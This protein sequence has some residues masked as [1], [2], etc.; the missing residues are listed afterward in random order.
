MRS[1]LPDRRG[2]LTTSIVINGNKYHVTYGEYRDGRLAEIFAAGPKIGS[3]ARTGL[4]EAVTAASLA[5]Q[6]GCSVEELLRAL[7]R[8]GR[9]EPEG[10]L[11]IILTKWLHIRG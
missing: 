6:H 1:R 9:N 2:A 3:D 11:A 5:L 8:D 10:V 4:T 7:P